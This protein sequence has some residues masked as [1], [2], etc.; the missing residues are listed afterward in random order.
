MTKK[1]K[2]VLVYVLD[3]LWGDGPNANWAILGVFKKQD[4][5]RKVGKASTRSFRIEPYVVE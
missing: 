1:K 5:A 4:A 2:R 3:V